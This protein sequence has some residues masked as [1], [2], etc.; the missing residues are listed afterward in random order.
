MRDFVAAASLAGFIL[1][2]CAQWEENPKETTGTV[3]G[4]ALGGLVGA[5]FGQGTGRVAATGAGV[6]LGAFLGGEIGR[7]LDHADRLAMQSTT[8]TALETGRTGEP[9]RWQNP[10]TGNFGTVTPLATTESD[11]TICRTYEQTITVAGRLQTGYGTACRQ[12]D[13]QW[14]IVR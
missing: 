13:G 14:R 7:S 9:L 12:P 2:G 10:Q 3:A 11:G 1:A 6:L 4:A 5:G 8:R